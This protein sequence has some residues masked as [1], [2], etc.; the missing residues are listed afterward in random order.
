VVQ[1]RERK[2]AVLEHQDKVLPEETQ[3]LFLAITLLAVAAV[4]ALLEKR[5]LVHPIP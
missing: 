3:V 5:H 2:L 1:V 4:L